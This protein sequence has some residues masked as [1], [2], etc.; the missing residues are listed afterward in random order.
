M[1]RA[2]GGVLLVLATACGG[3][4]EPA[5][6]RFDAAAEFA[7]VTAAHAQFAAA[8]DRLE[9]AQAPGP[10]GTS[11]GTALS[12]EAAAAYDAA[13]TRDQLALAAFL[14]QALN[15]APDRPETREA[16]GW[17]ADAAVANARYLLDRGGD[18]RQALEPLTA[19]ARAYGALGLP[20]P[21]RLAAAEQEARRPPAPAATPTT[22]A[23]APRPRR[24][25]R[26]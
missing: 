25:R 22:A 18:A 9:R 6:G 7:K 4:P 8:R 3:R 14:N 5:S 20:V 11:G 24:R 15:V 23:P 12:R 19:A 16:L 1:R 17:Y 10:P 13:F 2:G 21:A 26:R